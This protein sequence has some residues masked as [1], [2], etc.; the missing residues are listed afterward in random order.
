[1]CHH[2]LLPVFE[3]FNLQNLWFFKRLDINE[4]IDCF[5]QEAELYA[6]AY[7]VDN[8]LL[9]VANNDSN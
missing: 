7:G 2:E 4:V 9:V 8:T 3:N 1:M 5:E 6:T